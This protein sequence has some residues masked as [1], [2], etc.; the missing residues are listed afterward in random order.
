MFKNTLYYKYYF[1]LFYK[2]NNEINIYIIMY[3]YNTRKNHK[4][5]TSSK[6]KKVIENIKV[7]R[8]VWNSIK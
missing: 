3:D 2:K 1:R 4:Y 7:Y 5:N 6:I 8:N